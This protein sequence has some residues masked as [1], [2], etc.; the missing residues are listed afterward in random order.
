MHTGV[1]YQEVKQNILNLSERMVLSF[2]GGITSSTE[3][4]HWTIMSGNGVDDVRIM[5][6]KSM[7]DD[8]GRPH[9]LAISASICF[10]VPVL[11]KIVFN[12]I[13]NESNRTEVRT[14]YYM[15]VYIY[16]SRTIM[17]IEFNS[18]F[19]HNNYTHPLRHD[20]ETKMSNFL[21]TSL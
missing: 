2:S 14:I 13:Q 20:L 10:L 7:D 16:I 12:Y 4:Y 15:C 6:R 17:F 11:P 5:S 19:T 18:F 21:T 1:P 9:G 3:A 8:P